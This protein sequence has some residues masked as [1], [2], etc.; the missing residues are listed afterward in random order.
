MA[1]NNN[2]FDGASYGLK[3]NDNGGQYQHGRSYD[4]VKKFEITRV[5]K[6]MMDSTGK[7]SWPQRRECHRFVQNVINEVNSGGLVD[8]ATVE[9]NHV[10]GIGARSLTVTDEAVLIFFLQRLSEPHSRELPKYSRPNN[11][12]VCGNVYNQSLVQILSSI[13]EKS[14]EVEDGA[15][16]TIQDGFNDSGLLFWPSLERSPHGHGLSQRCGKRI[17]PTT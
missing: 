1:A 12:N 10:R 6:E 2:P 4:M 5:Y 15:S 14:P 16:W 11:R 8:P 7:A 13:Q 9:R 17:R 3:T